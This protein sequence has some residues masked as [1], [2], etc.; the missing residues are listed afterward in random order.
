MANYLVKNSPLKNALN[1]VQR[2][3]GAISYDS[4]VARPLTLC[5]L[6]LKPSVW[7]GCHWHPFRSRHCRLGQA[8]TGWASGHGGGSR[9]PTVLHCSSRGGAMF[10][11][12]R[13]RKAQL[14]RTQRSVIPS[15]GWQRRKAKPFGAQLQRS[16]TLSVASRHDAKHRVLRGLDEVVKVK[17]PKN[18]IIRILSQFKLD[19]TFIH[20]FKN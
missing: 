4:V 12:A 6:R 18:I 1:S 10:A 5:I 15:V 11:I 13:M 17:S 2:R 3:H 20:C 7:G 16:D 9:L 19:H 8:L 14:A